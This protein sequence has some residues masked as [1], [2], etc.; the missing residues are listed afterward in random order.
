MYCPETRQILGKQTLDDKEGERLAV[1]ELVTK[2]GR[3]V[4]PGIMSGDAGIVSPEVTRVMVAAGHGFVL[5]IK[6]NSGLAYEEAGE[7]AWDHVVVADVDQSKGHGRDEL[8]V[9]KAI[10][11]E[12]ADFDELEKYANI[13]VVLQ[14]ERTAKYTKSA[15]ETSDKSYY[16]GDAVFASLDLQMQA[17][18]VRDHWAQESYHWVKDVVMKEDD[19]WQR[20]SNGSR[21]LSTIRSIVAKL[22]RAVCDSPKRFIDRFTADPQNMILGK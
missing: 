12:F 14:V 11:S 1:I 9:T 6:G 4:L 7:M 21:A 22:G 15:R 10:A 19:S 3:G 5:Q 18:Y 16:I 13:G 17:R 8:R 20:T 2:T